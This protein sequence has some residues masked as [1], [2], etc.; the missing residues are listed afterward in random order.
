MQSG[1]TLPHLVDTVHDRAHK[2]QDFVLPANRVKVMQRYNPLERDTDLQS[3]IN[4]HEKIYSDHAMRQLTT[5]HG[6]PAKFA[7]RVRD[8]H[9]DRFVDL[10]NEMITED[11]SNRLVRVNNGSIRAFLSDRY[12]IVDHHMLMP[13]VM[14]VVNESPVKLEVAQAAVTDSRMMLR[15][16]RDVPVETK[17]VGDVLK[18]GFSITNSEIG[19]GATA[20]QSFAKRLVCLNGMQ[21]N[22]AGDRMVRRHLGA[23]LGDNDTPINILSPETLQRQAEAVVMAVTDTAKHLLSDDHLT[24]VLDQ[25]NSTQERPLHGNMAGAMEIVRTIVGLDMD[26][27]AKAYANLV[28]T[29]D[30]TQWGLANAVTFAAH[31]TDDYDEQNKLIEAGGKILDLNP[32][33][34]KAVAN[35]DEPQKVSWSTTRLAA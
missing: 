1:T 11:D 13:A 18:I 33:Q 15:I 28:D 23:V 9:P 25:V 12:K 10:L 35:A 34:W 19:S 4:G 24:S 2:A 3:M 26:E 17:R 31:T 27:T 30:R 29:R 22:V 14:R 16:V 7:S 6:W 5:H 21:V 8:D 32:A 20:V